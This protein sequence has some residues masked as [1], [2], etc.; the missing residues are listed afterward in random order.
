MDLFAT[1]SFL[2][3]FIAG[4]AALLAPC[5]ITVLL[6]SYLGSV[7]NERYKVF[8][9]TFVFFLGLVVVFLPIGLA[10]AAIGQAFNR[11]HNAI[12]VLGGAFMA[13]LGASLLTDRKFMPSAPWHFTIPVGKR[14]SVF[15]LG[16]FSG[17]ATLC[18]APVLAGVVALSV[19]PGSIVWGS[20]YTI[21]Y[22]L[23]MAA[24]LFAAA[25]L[26]DK[27]D[28]AARLFAIKKPISY[29]LAGKQITVR[30]VDFL[31]GTVFLAMGLIILYLAA[32]GR[33]YVN[34]GYQTSVNIFVAKAAQK[35]LNI[36]GALPQI[37]WLFAVILTT[38]AIIIYSFRLKKEEK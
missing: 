10:G 25:V 29:R 5:C 32:T 27:F 15:A 13:L 7:L 35:I 23:G 12:F 26:L 28:L 22:A 16:I 14:H 34:A 30:L 19:L 21:A 8:L 3:A 1:T 31:T 4:F 9:M 6:P 37:I 24:P 20:A 11:Y 18:C 38:I 17:L 2:A 33:L 36:F